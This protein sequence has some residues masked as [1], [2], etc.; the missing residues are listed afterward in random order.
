M[1]AL[2]DDNKQIMDRFSRGLI[3]GIIGGIAMNLWSAIAVNILNWQ[4]IRFIDWAGIIIPEPLQPS[5]GLGGTHLPGTMDFKQ[6]IHTYSI[7][8][9]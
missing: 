2:F 9:K 7:C 6:Y 8:L 5:S 1:L 4:I 3:A